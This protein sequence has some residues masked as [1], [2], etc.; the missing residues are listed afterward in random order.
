MKNEW[1]VNA[2]HFLYQFITL[3]QIFTIVGEVFF[4][5]GVIVG[6]KTI[7]IKTTSEG[8]SWAA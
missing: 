4:M 2:K 6:A 3:R 5:H 7:C 1:T 8:F